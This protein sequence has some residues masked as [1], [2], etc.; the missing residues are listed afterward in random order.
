MHKKIAQKFISEFYQYLRND[1]AKLR[2]FYDQTAEKTVFQNGN[3]TKFSGPADIYQCNQGLS[4]HSFAVKAQSS[5]AAGDNVIVH[6]SGE[7]NPTTQN[8]MFFTQCFMLQRMSPD[9]KHYCVQSET[10]HLV[11]PSQQYPHVAQEHH[12]PIPEPKLTLNHHVEPPNPRPNP[13]ATTAQ[14]LQSLP[15]NRY[16]HQ[17]HTI[18]PTVHS[19]QFQKESSHQSEVNQQRNQ[20][21]YPF[22]RGY[23]S[24]HDQRT[25]PLRDYKP[26]QKQIPSSHKPVNEERALLPAPS[27]S[28][29]KH[30]PHFKG[31]GLLPAPQSPSHLHNDTKSYSSQPRNAPTH[32]GLLPTPSSSKPLKTSWAPGTNK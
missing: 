10:L 1:T 7:L 30:S 11:L 24:Q 18:Q 22:E 6:C 3:E 21:Q 20:H 26:P 28:E 25:Q 13:H 9:K 4:I 29:Q 16:S 32:S 17:T 5:F 31:D 8:Q 12:Q 19:Q 2:S 23:D 27:T 15:D 14:P